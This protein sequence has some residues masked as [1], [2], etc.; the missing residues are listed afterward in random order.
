MILLNYMIEILLDYQKN[1]KLFSV[2]LKCFG[3]PILTFQT[4]QCLE[5]KREE[6]FYDEKVFCK[7]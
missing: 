3:K 5:E 1:V 4:A 7:Q 6:V 2:E